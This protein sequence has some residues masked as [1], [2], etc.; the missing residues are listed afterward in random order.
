MQMTE[1]CGTKRGSNKHCYSLSFKQLTHTSDM[2]VMQVA[3]IAPYSSAVSAVGDRTPPPPHTSTRHLS[4]YKTAHP[5]V[6]QCLRLPFPLLSF[7]IG[8]IS[9][10]VTSRSVKM[11]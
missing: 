5:A 8:L 4:L 6:A 10:M 9:T 1:G 7:V 3:T 11:R 2:Y